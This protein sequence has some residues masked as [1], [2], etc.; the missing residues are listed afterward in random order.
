MTENKRKFE[1]VDK[2]AKM[3]GERARIDAKAN[4]TAI[5]YNTKH[6]WVKEYYD[7][8]IESM[9][10]EKNRGEKMREKER[11]NRITSL[12]QR[13]WEQQPDMRFNQL[14]SNLQHIYS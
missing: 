5:V 3:T 11:I 10:N 2:W 9:D 13:I 7:G 12:I 8:T 1:W 6:G 14:I 4:K